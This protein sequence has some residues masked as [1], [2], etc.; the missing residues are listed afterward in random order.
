MAKIVCVLYDDPVDGYPTEYA[1][2]GVPRIE[3][4]PGGQTVP[5]PKSIDFTPGQLLGQRVGRAGAASVSRGARPHV[6][7]D[8]GQGGTRLGLR[9]R[10][11]RGRGR[12]L[13]AVLAGVPD[14]R[15]NRRGPEPQAGHHRRHRLGPRGPGG[16]HRPEHHRR[17]GDVLE[18]H[19]RVRAR[20]D[21]DPVVGPQLHPVVRVGGQGWVEH[22]RLRPALLRPRRHDGRHGRRRSHRSRGAAAPA[23]IRRAPALHGSSPARREHRA[24]ARPR[25]PPD[26][27]VTGRGV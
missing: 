14:C 17:G 6:R 25:V 18:Q 4:Y 8:L 19:Q 7:R 2:D 11:A 16:G 26:R 22:R 13:P 3:S 21:D 27:R 5:S 15:A 12:D 10:A 20:G 24:R 23:P 9:S 1:R